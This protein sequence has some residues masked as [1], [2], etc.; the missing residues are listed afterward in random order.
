MLLIRY[1]HKN[2]LLTMTKWT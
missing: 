1:L 2:M